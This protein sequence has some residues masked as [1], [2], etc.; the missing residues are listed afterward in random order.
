MQ[1]LSPDIL[2]LQLRHRFVRVVDDCCVNVLTVASQLKF[3]LLRNFHGAKSLTF[4]PNRAF[5][6][7]QLQGVVKRIDWT[8]LL[9]RQVTAVTGVS[10]SARA[11]ARAESASGR[12]PLC[13]FCV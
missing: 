9:N 6:Q 8:R 7:R 12:A 11:R 5:S 3:G 13:H 10:N 1:P 2:I 4:I